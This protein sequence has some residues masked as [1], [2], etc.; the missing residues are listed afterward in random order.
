M[1]NKA[2]INPKIYPSLYMVQTNRYSNSDYI[3]TEDVKKLLN[4]YGDDKNYCLF[5]KKHMIHKYKKIAIDNKKAE[6]KQKKLDEK[7]KIMEEKKKIKEDKQKMKE[8]KVDLDTKLTCVEILKT[9]S[10]KGSPC[11]C[12][13]YQGDKCKR[14]YN[15][16]TVSNVLT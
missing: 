9:G 4:Y 1:T 5:H 13:V 2:R 6:E 16:N 3:F 12:K 7:Q 10:N 8:Q 11:G 14:H 15:K